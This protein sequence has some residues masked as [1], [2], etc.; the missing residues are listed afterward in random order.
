M[1]KQPTEGMQ[2]CFHIFCHKTGKPPQDISN[3]FS[4]AYYNNNQ[5][6]PSIFIPAK[7]VDG[8]TNTNELMEKSVGKESE[9]G[10]LVEV[11]ELL[12]KGRSDGDAEGRE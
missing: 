3:Y 5:K 6:S 7:A 9:G 2:W 11:G 12:C 4:C 10:D 8:K 1:T